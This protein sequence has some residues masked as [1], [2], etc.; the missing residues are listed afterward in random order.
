MA[1]EPAGAQAIVSASLLA[2]NRIWI[3]Y[4][5]YISLRLWGFAGKRERRII[6]LC[7]Q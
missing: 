6:D 3:V 4:S 2:Y 1:S 5:Q 7:Y